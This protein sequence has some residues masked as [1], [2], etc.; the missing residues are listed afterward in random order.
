MVFGDRKRKKDAVLVLL[1]WPSEV[2]DF[3]FS[4]LLKSEE[5]DIRLFIN[6]LLVGSKIR[7]SSM[8]SASAQS[9]EDEAW[10]TL[11]KL[12]GAEGDSDS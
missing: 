11:S 7:E 5:W 9:K 10:D 6:A 12:V 4:E 3:T 1:T 8:A 2:T